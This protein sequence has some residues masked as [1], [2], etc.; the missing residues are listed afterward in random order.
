M[1]KELL[2]ILVDKNSSGWEWPNAAERSF[3]DYDGEVRFFNSEEKTVASYAFFVKKITNKTRSFGVTAIELP[4]EYFVTRAQ[5][6]AALVAKN[7]V[8][9]W[10]GE[11]LPPVGAVC[12]RNFYDRS[13]DNW[14]K[15]TILF[16]GKQ[17]MVMDY[18]GA[19]LFLP[20][21]L[22]LAHFR[23]LRTEAE[24][25]REAAIDPIKK[26]LCSPSQT[27][28][29]A[30]KVYDAIAAGRIPGVKLED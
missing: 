4:S 1:N 28:A 19:E 20:T 22:A 15:V 8:A 17:T 29:L 24:R 27:V 7:A 2:Y 23:P 16:S 13:G 26:I 25:K 6:E 9:T 5:Y 11:G 18:D 12:E 21:S 30:G 3:Q 14:K 10:N